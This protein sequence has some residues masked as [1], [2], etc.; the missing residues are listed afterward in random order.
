MLAA[1]VL[2]A[3]VTLAAAA[4]ALLAPLQ[5]RLRQDFVA[6]GRATVIGDKTP[7]GILAVNAQGLPP[8]E[9]KH[10]LRAAVEVLYHETTATYVVWTDRLD[11]YYDTDPDDPAARDKVAPRNPVGAALADGGTHYTLNGNVLV[12]ATRYTGEPARGSSSG[13]SFV[14]EIIRHV[15]Y[16]GTADSAVGTAFVYAALVGLAVAVLLGIALSSRLLRRLRLLRDASRSLEESDL[17]AFESP[18]DD[19]PDEIG[20]LARGLTTMHRRVRQQE[21]A[22]QAFIATASHELRTP[23]MSLQTTLE[24]LGEDLAYEPADVI[25]AR[26]RVASAQRQASRLSSLAKDLLDLSRLDAQLALRAE[27]VELTETARAVG[28]EFE[29]LGHERSVGVSLADTDMSV[30][31]QA[32]PGAV[33]RIVRILLDN[34]LRFA[35]ADT[36]VSV[37]IQRPPSGA[38]IEVTDEGPGVPNDEQELIFERFQ[39]GRNS[40][41]EGGFGLGLAIG[42]ELAARMGGRLELTDHSPGAR[43][44]LTLPAAPAADF[45]AEPSSPTAARP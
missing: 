4:L 2:T 35:P 7:L 18:S 25:D 41:G 17:S 36:T 20:E 30:W 19:V 42:S 1:L 21:Q 23:L 37:R 14:L 10:G 16:L 43:F 22:R 13:R 5:S 3:L 27:P 45:S 29:N 28:A 34:A 26:D 32:D 44:R 12:D 24:L 40:G 8:K 9:G 6:L 15:D 39:R 31:A 33:A 38:T 11:R